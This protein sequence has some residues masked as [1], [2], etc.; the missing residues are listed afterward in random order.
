MD[1]I[2][3]LSSGECGI[4]VDWI[5]DKYYTIDIIDKDDK[6]T[7]YIQV[8]NL[9]GSDRKDVLLVENMKAGICEIQIDPLNR[10]LIFRILDTTMFRIDTY[11]NDVMVATDLISLD[12]L[13][14]ITSQRIYMSI[15][16]YIRL[17]QFE[18]TKEVTRSRKA[19]KI[20]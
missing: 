10:Y 18:H 12:H 5:E 2:T 7:G 20:G 3:T 15:T 4:A 6:V 14:I 8:A 19:T 9:D 17:K 11:L 13:D 1:P 16:K